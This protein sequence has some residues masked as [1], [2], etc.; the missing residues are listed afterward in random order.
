[1][2]GM[3]GT[4]DVFAKTPLGKKSVQLIVAGDGNACSAD[5]VMG[6]RRR[7]LDGVL[8][9][10]RATFEGEV[11]LPFP[12]G[13]VAFTIDGTIEGDILTGVCRTKKFTF[14]ITGVRSA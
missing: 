10:N 2:A 1:M 7:H 12:I 6:D 8:D 4:Y 11:K 3:A 5:V 13:K 14:D 9:G